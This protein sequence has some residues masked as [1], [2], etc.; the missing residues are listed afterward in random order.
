[1]ALVKSPFPCRSCYV[2]PLEPFHDTEREQKRQ[3]VLAVS[4]VGG[5]ALH[6]AH[7]FG[8][9][10]MFSLRYSAGYMSLLCSPS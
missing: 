9:L 4:V 10:M 8:T 3:A 2:V 7:M 5:K 1:M 6:L